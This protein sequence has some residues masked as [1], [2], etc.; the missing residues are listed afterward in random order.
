MED[1]ELVFFKVKIHF[2]SISVK[3]MCAV[4]RIRLCTL[5]P[6]PKRTIFNQLLI[7]IL[8][9]ENILLTWNSVIYILQLLASLLA[10]TNVSA[11]NELVP[12]CWQWKEYSAGAEE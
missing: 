3:N 7:S 8:K 12:T 6:I 2:C 9:L 11:Y 1:Q 5:A 4:T 10:G